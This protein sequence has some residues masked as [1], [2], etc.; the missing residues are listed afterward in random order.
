MWTSHTYT[1]IPSLLSIPFPI[2]P[3]PISASQ[4][5]RS[6]QS[7]RLSSLL[8]AA[9]YNLFYIWECIRFNVTLSIHLTLSFPYC[10]HK[11]VLFI[12]IFIPAL[13]IGSSVPFFYIPYICVNIWYLFSL[14]DLLH[15]VYA[16]G[17]FISFQLTQICSFYGW[18]ILHCIYVPPF[19]YP[20]SMCQI[21]HAVGKN[22]V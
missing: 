16:L 14:S 9:S 11:F 15:S 19:L 1:Y 2:Y 5:S 20:F 13:Q 3:S 10:F 21:L 8:H 4:S 6:A 22:I 17:S 12:S 18:V 7:S